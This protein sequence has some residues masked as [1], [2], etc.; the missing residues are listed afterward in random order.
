VV[1]HLLQHRLIACANLF[2]IESAYWWQGALEHSPEIVSICKTR[3]EKWEKVRDEVAKVHP[4][5]V[6]CVVKLGAEA[7]AAFGSWIEEETG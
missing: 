5:E 6:P 1:D 3:P 4:Y 7:S 2:P